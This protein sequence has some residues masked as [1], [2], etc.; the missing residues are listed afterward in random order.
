[1]QQPGNLIIRT[2]KRR[3]NP[4]RRDERLKKLTS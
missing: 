4:G 1:M 3:L 2:N